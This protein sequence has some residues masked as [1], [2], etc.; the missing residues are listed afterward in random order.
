MDPFNSCDNLSRRHPLPSRLK[1]NQNQ[2][3]QK[4]VESEIQAMS[5]DKLYEVFHGSPIVCHF[6]YQLLRLVPQPVLRQI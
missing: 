1:D 3:F 2:T 5:K 6:K 4:H